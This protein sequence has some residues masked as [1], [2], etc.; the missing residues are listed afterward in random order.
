MA[1][2][3]YQVPD[4]VPVIPRL[5]RGISAFGCF[6]VTIT[7]ST[8][9]SAVPGSMFSGLATR[10]GKKSTAVVRVGRSVGRSLRRSVRV[11]PWHKKRSSA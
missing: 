3:T 11:E 7:L 8:T 10:Y 4:N 6:L 1:H 5:F 9:N 2:K